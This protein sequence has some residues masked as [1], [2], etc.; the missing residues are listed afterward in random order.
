MIV[1]EKVW[2]KSMARL[3][4]RDEDDDVNGIKRIVTGGLVDLIELES[5]RSVN[6]RRSDN[7]Y[8]H[9]HGSRRGHGTRHGN[10]RMVMSPGLGLG[11]STP[12]PSQESVISSEADRDRARSPA[13]G[14]ETG[15]GTGHAQRRE[16][17]AILET[18]PRTRGDMPPPQHQHPLI[19]GR[20]HSD[21]PRITKL[22][23]SS[24][25]DLFRIWISLGRTYYHVEFTTAPA[26]SARG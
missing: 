2:R 10:G 15:T 18:L 17:A 3:L 9:E 12:R 21:I 24:S 11:A 22:E 16:T 14:S 8:D 6:R 26:S 25:W 5:R 7:D 4:R 20:R 23:S 13:Y 1:R 19:I